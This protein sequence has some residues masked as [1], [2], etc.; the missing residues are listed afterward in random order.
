[1]HRRLKGGVRQ[2]R[3]RGGEN[4]SY[5][6]GSNR[7][8][9]LQV[10]GGRVVLRLGRIGDN[11]RGGGETWGRSIRW[12]GCRGRWQVGGRWQGGRWQAEPEVD[13]VH[14]EAP[15]CLTEKSLSSVILG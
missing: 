10:G 6:G 9:G 11:C 4:G 13:I 3:W 15:S 7:R 5:M 12:G 14:S 1:M 2:L 8:R